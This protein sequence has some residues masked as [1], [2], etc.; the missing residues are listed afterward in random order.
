MKIIKLGTKP[1]LS[2]RIIRCECCKTIYS[3]TDED[4]KIGYFI[5]YFKC[6]F[7]SKKYITDYDFS[8]ILPNIRKY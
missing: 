2:S 4:L 1:K 3:A 8:S 6:P 7:C 5:K